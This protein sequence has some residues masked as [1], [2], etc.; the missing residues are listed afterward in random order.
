MITAVDYY[1]Y[2]VLETGIILRSRRSGTGGFLQYPQVRDDCGRIGSPGPNPLQREEQ[3]C[4]GKA[5]AGGWSQARAVRVRK[6]LGSGVFEM[7]SRRLPLTVP[8]P[9]AD[10]V[11]PY[12]KIFSF[13]HLTRVRSTALAMYSMQQLAS[14]CS[15]IRPNRCHSMTS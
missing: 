9:W 3:C 8:V 7:F 11:L 15:T 1:Y 2:S 10:R 4:S 14:K 13:S 12:K 5:F 6:E